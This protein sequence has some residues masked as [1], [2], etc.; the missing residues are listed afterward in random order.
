[1][2]IYRVVQWHW[3]IYRLVQLGLNKV[4]SREI[5]LF[6]GFLKSKGYRLAI[7]NMQG[8]LKGKYPFV[9]VSSKV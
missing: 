6:D 2:N 9:T 3:K 1:M 8:F 4:S 7:G 5:S